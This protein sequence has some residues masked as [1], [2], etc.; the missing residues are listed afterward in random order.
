MCRLPPAAT[1]S[2]AA[3]AMRRPWPFVPGEPPRSETPTTRAGRPADPRVSVTMRSAQA[4][5]KFVWRHLGN[6]VP[7]DI[8]PACLIDSLWSPGEVA[9]SPQT[10]HMRGCRRQTLS[11]PG[12]APRHATRQHL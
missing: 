12:L 3:T 4:P 9:S 6:L 1:T 5:A 2:R 11:M 7:P 8:L 10:M